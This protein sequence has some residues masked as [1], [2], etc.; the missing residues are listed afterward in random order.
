MEDL[1]VAYT[2]EA[3]KLRTKTFALEIIRLFSELPRNPSAQVLGR[4]LLRSGTSVGANYRAVCRARSRADFIAKLKIVEEEADESA[5]WMELLAEGNFL[6]QNRVMQLADEAN[7][8]LAIIVSSINTVR[9][10]SKPRNPSQH[11]GQ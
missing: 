1:A 3:M 5:Y 2:P 11:I 6:P 10:Q 4:Q 8:I 7:Q 9:K